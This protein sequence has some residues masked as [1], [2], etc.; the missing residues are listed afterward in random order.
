MQTW[1]G[2]VVLVLLTA[3]GF[4]AVRAGWAPPSTFGARE[5]CTGAVPSGNVLLPFG[6]CWRFL[7][8]GSNQGTAWRGPSFDDSAW[9]EG[10]GAFWYDSTNADPPG[11]TLV[12]YGPNPSAKFITAYFRRTFEVSPSLYLRYYLNVVRDD[13]VVVYVNGVEVKRDNMP[14]SAVTHLT[15]ASGAVGGSDET[16]V[17]SYTLTPANLVTGT[18][19][20][21][22][23]VH[24]SGPAS[25]DMRFDLRLLGDDGTPPPTPT[26]TPSPTPVPTLPPPPPGVLRFASVGDFGSANSTPATDVAALIRSWNPEFI[27]TVGDNN[28]CDGLGLPGN[29]FDDC[30]GRY[31]HDFIYP[32]SGA[33][34]AGAAVNRFW[35]AL[36]NHDHDAGL[37][38]YTAF[39]DLP[40]NERYY[41]LVR[42]PVHFFV[43]DSD[44]READGNTSTSTQG[45]WLQ[46]QLAAS[47]SPWRVVVFHHPAY[48]S[49]SG[50]GSSPWMQWPFATWGATA[51]WQGH[52]H[53][54]ERLNLAGLPYVVNGL[55][56]R[57]I[58]G[59]GAPLSGSLVRYNGDYGAM[60]I[61]ADAC[62]MVHT[63]INRQRVVLDTLT[64]TV[65]SCA[66]PTPSPTSTDTPTATPTET[67]TPTATDTP[68]STPTPTPSPTETPT[69]TPTD[70]PTATPTPTPSPTETPTPT[71]TD[72]PTPTPTDTPTATPTPTP[73]STPTFTPTPTATRSP[74][75]RIYIADVRR[76]ASVD[77]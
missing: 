4:A 11:A 39:F 6:A 22:V 15:T 65:P 64:Q 55:G 28:Y 58:Y 8:D 60:L 18:N 63:F 34:G 71:A 44:S 27:V 14:A 59:F 47:A 5:S 26:P 40:G 50:H 48:S 41:D 76:A 16:R 12:S 10:A 36:G 19:T 77:W 67:P 38:N 61:E 23:E 66:T 35:P 74:L 9:S 57:S 75:Y 53:T 13:G 2:L 46:A 49:S 37:G 62:Q 25:S 17:Y 72:S 70:T 54:Y 20:I 43:V 7:D 45:Q 68:T 32:Y 1:R 52:D 30:V 33:Y 42:G 69:S 56:G 24:Q 3:S 73:S 51:V 21:A 31:Y 29:G